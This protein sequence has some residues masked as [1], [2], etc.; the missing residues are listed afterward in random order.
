MVEPRD[1]QYEET[2][3]PRNPPN[4]V[5]NR[6]V[7]RAVLGSYLGPIIVLCV[8][9]GLGFAYWSRRDPGREHDDNRLNPSIGTTGERLKDDD[10]GRQLDQGG[11]DPAP[12]PKS[13]KDEIEYRGRQ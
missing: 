9:L 10:R 2:E 11:G 3:H 4:A 8:I 13:T 6:N 1:P 12:Q 5:L 7:R